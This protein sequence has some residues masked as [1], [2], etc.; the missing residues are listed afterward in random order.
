MK[1][2]SDNAFILFDHLH[3]RALYTSL[4]EA[5]TLLSFDPISDERNYANEESFRKHCCVNG[6]GCN[7]FQERRPINNCIEYQEPSMGMNHQIFY[8][9]IAGIVCFQLHTVATVLCENFIIKL[10]YKFAL[11]VHWC[12]CI[13]HHES[14]YD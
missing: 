8:Y 2:L 13:L 10:Q 12:C 7:L 6:G 9:I 5:G 14:A 11:H 3:N 4:P 1:T